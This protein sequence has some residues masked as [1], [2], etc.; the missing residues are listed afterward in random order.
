LFAQFA[1]FELDCRQLIDQD[2]KLASFGNRLGQITGSR[3]QLGYTLL[4]AAELRA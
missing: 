3:V 4:N 1:E 2:L